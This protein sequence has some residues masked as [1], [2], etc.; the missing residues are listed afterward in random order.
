MR[1]AT[2]AGIEEL[3]CV[4][5]FQ[6][7]HPMRGATG[8]EG[9][10]LPH[11]RIS[12]HAPHAGCDRPP[13]RPQPRAYNFNP[14]TP[15][16]VRRQGGCGE[17]DPVYFNPRTPCG[18]RLVLNMETGALTAFQSTH[19]M[20]GATSSTSM[21]FASN[22]ISI[23][24]PHAGCDIP[25]RQPVP[26]SPYFNPR[27]PCGVRRGEDLALYLSGQISIHAPHAGC[28]APGPGSCLYR[29]HFN[30]R[31]PCGVRPRCSP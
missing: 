1:G 21:P 20:R 11:E 18:V 29:A 25:A 8:V 24:A 19:P 7:T 22:S 3:L 28:D 4:I 9:K 5:R 15:C 14:R 27:T 2:L 6:S 17:L 31:T 12:I 30:P 13:F 10:G 16:G 26:E 23:H